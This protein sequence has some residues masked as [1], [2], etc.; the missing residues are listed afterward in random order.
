MEFDK[1]VK[2]TPTAEWMKKTYDEL[3]KWLFNGVLGKC[4]F[5]VFTEGT[6]SQW[7][8]LGFFHFAKQYRYSP[9]TRKMYS[10]LGINFPIDKYNIYELCAPEI[11]IN[12]NY[13][14]T[15]YAF[16]SIL[17]HEMCHY[18][19][20]MNGVIPRQGHGVE[21]K[22]I[23][24]MVSAR[25]NNYFKI[26]THERQEVMAQLELSPN[27][28]DKRSR[29]E[30]SSITRA[31]CML[32]FMNDNTIRLVRTTQD[33]VKEEVMSYETKRDKCTKI[34]EIRDINFINECQTYGYITNCR[35]YRYWSVEGKKIVENFEN[36]NHKVLYEH[37][38]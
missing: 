15:E 10:T 13:K 23:G 9:K 27:F 32:L 30:D 28:L 24:S 12:G 25:S 18:Y 2:I 3:N 38:K 11:K 22:Q 16:A 29:R 7:H 34:V 19:T 37:K 4:K 35:T 6:G 17:L 5:K 1:T 20:Y 31:F 14:G 8:R 26:Q 33:K 36:Y 21:F